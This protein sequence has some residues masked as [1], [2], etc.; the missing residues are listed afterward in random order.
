[1]DVSQLINKVR[2]IRVSMILSLHHLH[3]YGYARTIT[4]TASPLIFSL[5]CGHLV[6]TLDTMHMGRQCTI[7]SIDGVNSELSTFVNHNLV[8]QIFCSNRL[9]GVYSPYQNV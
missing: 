7:A 8:L 6:T 9:P 5:H 4:C 3:G 1:M 2:K